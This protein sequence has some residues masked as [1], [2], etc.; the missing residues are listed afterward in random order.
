VPGCGGGELFLVGPMNTSSLPQMKRFALSPEAQ[1]I[2]ELPGGGEW[3]TGA[4]CGGEEKYL[5]PASLPRV[6]ELW[7]MEIV[8]EIRPDPEEDPDDAESESS[9]R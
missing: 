6:E 2:V 1:T 4:R 5:E 7:D 3:L 9:S 8:F